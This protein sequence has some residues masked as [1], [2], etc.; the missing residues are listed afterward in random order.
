NVSGHVFLLTL[1][2]FVAL[3]NE[4]HKWSHM[5]K[6]PAVARFMMSCHL[7]LT[8][9]GH[10]KHHI[11]NHDQSY[12]ITTG[13]MNGVLDHVNFWRVAETVVTALT[14]EIPRANDKYLLGK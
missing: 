12:C 10:R 1:T 8:P 4:V 2:L 13:W 3:T 9:R 11:G 6:P 7:I 5:A 14:G